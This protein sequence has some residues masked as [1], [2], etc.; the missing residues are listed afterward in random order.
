MKPGVKWAQ[1]Y[2]ETQT[3]K[4]III[5]D[6]TFVSSDDMNGGDQFQ[7]VLRTLQG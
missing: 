1:S 2:E 6:E 4:L 3:N 5:E 7:L